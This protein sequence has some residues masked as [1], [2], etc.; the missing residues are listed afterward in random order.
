[1]NRKPLCQRLALALADA[2]DAMP[3]L[4][5]CTFAVAAVLVGNGSKAAFLR[6]ARLLMIGQ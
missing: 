4:A 6:V 3:W 1:M 2:S 5:T